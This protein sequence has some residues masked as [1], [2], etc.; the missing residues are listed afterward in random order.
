MLH[1]LTNLQNNI[2]SICNQ[3]GAVVHLALQMFQS[4]RLISQDKE[5]YISKR[6]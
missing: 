5:I 1:S 3:S 4:I 6:L 2:N